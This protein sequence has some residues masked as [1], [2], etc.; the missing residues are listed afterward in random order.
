MTV[1]DRI[2]ARRESLGI[3]QTELANVVGTTKQQMYK[4]ENDVITNIPYDMMERIAVAL[5][6]TP[7]HLVGWDALE[8]ATE[9]RF[10]IWG[11]LNGM[12]IDELKSVLDYAEF[13]NFK[14][15]AE[16]NGEYEYQEQAESIGKR[17]KLR[18]ERL[19][20]TQEDLAISLG[21]KSKSSINKIELGKQQLTQPNIL[22]MAK[23]LRTSVDYIMGWSKGELSKT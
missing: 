12:G 4:Y 13:I 18:R 15:K 9:L 10:S 1:G 22:A 7:Q 19:G 14:R 3:S 23:A 16:T 20:I 2:K 11:E 6:V 17:I 8:R 21:Y 5:S